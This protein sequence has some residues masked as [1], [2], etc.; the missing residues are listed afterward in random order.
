MALLHLIHTEC[1]IPT[2]SQCH[3]MWAFSRPAS[4]FDN[5]IFWSNNSLLEKYKPWKT[6]TV[7]MDG[8]LLDVDC[9]R[10]LAGDDCEV[11]TA[12][13]KL[14]WQSFDRIQELY[15]Y[16]ELRSCFALES[17][18]KASNLYLSPTETSYPLAYSLIIH[19]NINQVFRLLRIIYRINNIY[20]IHYDV[21]SKPEFKAFFE[22]LA[23][24]FQNIFIAH[25]IEDVVW[26]HPSLLNAQM[27]CLIDLMKYRDIF[28]WKYVIN[29]NGLELPLRTNREVVEMLQIAS[30]HSIID[31]YDIMDP[32]N[33]L[34]LKYKV[35]QISLWNKKMTVLSTNRLGSI[36][37][38]LKVYKSECF[39]ALTPHFVQFLLEDSL[40]QRYF[41]YLQEVSCPEEFFY[42]TMGVYYDRAFAHPVKEN[43]IHQTPFDVSISRFMHAAAYNQYELCKG[44]YRHSMCVFGAGD[45]H[46]ITQLH[47]GG[48]NFGQMPYN[49]T[50]YGTNPRLARDALK[51][52]FLNKYDAYQDHSVMD[53][54]EQR[55]V[56]Q[57]MLEYYYDHQ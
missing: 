51:A 31:A 35:N 48:W 56:K 10:L 4:G 52:L 26:G 32:T 6:G 28:P 9:C 54:M 18:F 23:S 53:C 24:C 49:D 46:S 33:D 45:L 42:A 14:R 38:D 12:R 15:V 47:I 27:N 5:Q 16:D 13:Q 8:T 7:S 25:R 21:K 19:T 1:S 57:N 44:S 20:C 17:K 41:R 29:L 3:D 34:R 43:T 40:A 39:V 22:L 2:T 37:G 11:I 50:G 30:G 55:L 36:P